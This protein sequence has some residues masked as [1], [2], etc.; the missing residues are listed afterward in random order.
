MRYD[1]FLS[2]FDGTLVRADGTIS[3]RNIAAIAEYRRRGGIF[4]V[5]TG[6][7]MASIRPR[8]KE[9]GLKEGLVAA[10]QGAM[11]ADIATGE[12]LKDDVLPPEDCLRA[13][14][15]FESRDLHI[16]IY[17]DDILYSNRDDEALKTYERICGV[18]G[19]IVGSELLS[20]KIAREG[21]RVVKVLAMVP[22]EDCIAVKDWTE[23]ALGEKFSVSC[24]SDYLVEV[25]GRDADKGSAVRFLSAHY[26]IPVERIAA[27]GDQFNDLPLLMAA[28]GR[29]AVANAVEELKQCAIAVPSVEDNGV[30]VTIEK[31]AMG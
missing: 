18:K 29:F 2:D 15:L 14:R 10:Y 3:Q 26:G 16:H 5:V 21:L 9:L 17:A 7:M 12:L 24:S 11:I 1:L 28:G 25:T 31:Y 23:R 30:A 20:E 6:R 22:K 19:R 13:V 4:A 8:L 27:I